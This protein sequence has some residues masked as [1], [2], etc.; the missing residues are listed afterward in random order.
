[1][2]QQ[3]ELSLESTL[4]LLSV[5]EI[6][7]LKDP[8]WLKII[9]EDRRIERKPCSMQ[10]RAL[11]IYFSMWGNTA[12][13]G[14]IIVIGMEDNGEIGGILKASPGQ[15]NEVERTGDTFCPDARY[16]FK[17]VEIQNKNG[18]RDQ[19]LI[20]RVHYNEK[21]VVRTTDGQAW[22]RRGESK[23]QLKEEE[24][25]E[26]QIEKGELSWER[27]ETNRKFPEDFDLKMIQSFSD[28]VIAN[29][30]LEHSASPEEILVVRRLGRMHNGKFIPNKACALL[31]CKDPCIEIPGCR[32]RFLRFDGKDEGF[33]EKYNAVKDSWIEG[34]IPSQ[35]LQIEKVMEGQLREYSQLGRDGKFVTSPEYPKPAWYEAIVNAVCH[36]SYNLQNIPIF[37]R[38]FDDRLEIESP[39]GFMPYVTPDN[40]Y[41]QHNPRNPDLMNA[42][43]FLD[44]VKCHHEG[45]RR[46]RETMEG[47]Q[48]PAPI[49]SESGKTH[50]QFR[51]V[52]KNNVEHRKTWL[53]SDAKR[54][55]GEVI[56]QSLTEHEMRVINHVAEFGNISVTDAVRITNKAW[57]TCKELLTKLVKMGILT[58]VHRSDILRDSKAHF[59]LASRPKKPN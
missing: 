44:Y 57:E 20:F 10:A 35:L 33:G 18:L 47:L 38:M 56:F 39:G 8:N 53:D 30:G 19:L 25:R 16:E 48:L 55:V 59:V 58:H 15:L 1:M 4:R 6:Y 5:E 2:A 11:S 7:N 24:I 28:A 50:P 45:T 9:K 17:R 12:P 3:F 42:L 46:M 29:R 13:A 21:K 23:R 32:I 36:R 51:V 54:I 43:Y 27:E 40:I 14:G 41:E 34:N 22:V 26:L 31:F 37:I 52:L 49:F